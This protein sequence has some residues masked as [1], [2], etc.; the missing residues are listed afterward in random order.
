VCRRRPNDTNQS[1]TKQDS[2]QNRFSSALCAVMIPC[3]AP[4]KNDPKLAQ[5]CDAS[6]K[7]FPQI[8][9][10]SPNHPCQSLLELSSLPCNQIFLQLRLSVNDVKSQLQDLEGKQ[11]RNVR[12][13]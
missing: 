3:L 10:C 2:G 8:T 4:L 12:Q 13:V 6:F 7:V 11:V 1:A 9:P 5:P